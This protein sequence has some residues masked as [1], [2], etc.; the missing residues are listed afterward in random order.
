M[1]INR[2]KFIKNGTSLA[3]LSAIG[4]GTSD[5]AGLSGRKN[6]HTSTTS[7]LVEAYNEVRIHRNYV[8]VFPVMPKREKCA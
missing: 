8:P 1:N 4:I 6:S 3:A 7:G 2:R 5:M